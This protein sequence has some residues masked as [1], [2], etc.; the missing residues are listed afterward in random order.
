MLPKSP[1]TYAQ[2]RRGVAAVQSFAAKHGQIW[3]ETATGDVGIDGQLEFVDAE[4]F[5]TG[6]TLAIQVKSGPSFFQNRMIGGWKFY[7]GEKH[8]TYW[9]RYPLPVILV[10]HDPEA[11]L[12]YWTDARQALRSPESV[13]KAIEVSEHD[14]L[15]RTEL[16]RLFQNAGVQSEIFI[17][18]L[19]DVISTLISRRC[20]NASFSVSFFDLFTQGLTN[21]CRSLYFGMDLAMTA[22]EFN[23]EAAESKFG[24]GVGAQE[25]EFLFDYIRFLL[26][27][28]LADVDFSDCLIDWLD[29]EMQPHFVAPLT[30]RGRDLV[31][32]IRARESALVSSGDLAVDG[33]SVVQEGFF[34]M[35]LASYFQRLPRIREFQ[36]VVAG[37]S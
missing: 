10:L 6:R 9:E 5:A 22:A 33:R 17:P 12:S 37:G 2:E 14:V 31:K 18:N 11:G 4:G 32:A 35:Q 21:I 7:P 1:H 23:S 34:G 26:A 24:I 15:E 19:D 25:H 20:S 3:R 36:T 28:H 29:R 27:Q 30:V 13:G 8:R 16:P